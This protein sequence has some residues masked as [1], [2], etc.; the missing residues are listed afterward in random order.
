V[1]LKPITE[2][3]IAYYLFDSYDGGVLP[4]TY[5]STNNTMV[6][7]FSGSIST[8]GY[9]LHYRRDWVSIT[10][11]SF[12]A[13]NPNAA[14]E[15]L[16]RNPEDRTFVTACTYH[17]SYDPATGEVR[18]NADSLDMVLFLDGHTE[19][20]PSDEVGPTMAPRY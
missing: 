2:N 15:L 17:R 19:K 3:R 6:P 16:N 12:N 11:G 8:P 9:E 1:T 10:A 4:P 18:P 13:N 14:R 5:R 7:V 20:R